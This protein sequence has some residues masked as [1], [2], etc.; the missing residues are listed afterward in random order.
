MSQGRVAE[1]DL[2]AMHQLLHIKLKVGRERNTHAANV[3]GTNGRRGRHTAQTRQCLPAPTISSRNRYSPRFVISLVL[4]WKLTE[5]ELEHIERVFSMFDVSI[6]Q[7]KV[8]GSDGCRTF[9][10]PDGV[11][12]PLRRAESEGPAACVTARA[13]LYGEGSAAGMTPRAHDDATLREQHASPVRAPS[14]PRAPNTP[15]HCALSNYLCLYLFLSRAR[16]PTRPP[17]RPQVPAVGAIDRRAF[18]YAMRRLRFADKTKRRGSWASEQVIREV[19]AGEYPLFAQGEDD[20]SYLAYVDA[21]GRAK[22]EILNGDD[23]GAA[24]ASALSKLSLSFG[25]PSSEAEEAEALRRKRAEFTVASSYGTEGDVWSRSVEAVG[26]RH[27][28][29]CADLFGRALKGGSGVNGPN[30]ITRRDLSPVLQAVRPGLGEADVQALCE[31]A[32]VSGRHGVSFVDVV[33]MVGYC[34]LAS[35]TIGGVSKVT[36]DVNDHAAGRAAAQLAMEEEEAQKKT[37]WST[38]LKDA[39]ETSERAFSDAAAAATAAANAGAAAA[40]IGAAV[41]VR[42][43][44]GGQAHLRSA[45]AQMDEAVASATAAAEAALPSEVSELA[46][47]ASTFASA[48]AG[49]AEGVGGAALSSVWSGLDAA[50]ALASGGPPPQDSDAAARQ[51]LAGLG[52]VRG[53]AGV[54]EGAE[55]ENKRV[56]AKRAKQEA[57]AKAA[58]AAAAEAARKSGAAAMARAAAAAAMDPVFQRQVIG[59]WFKAKAARPGQSNG[60]AWRENLALVFQHADDDGN[61]LVS[62]ADFMALLDDLELDLSDEEAASRFAEVDVDGSGEISFDEFERFFEVVIRDWRA[63]EVG[64]DGRIQH[65]YQALLTLFEP[66]DGIFGNNG[67]GKRKGFLL[68][69]SRNGYQFWS[70]KDPA[71]AKAAGHWSA[72]LGFDDAREAF[73]L[74]AAYQTGIKVSAGASGT[75]VSRLAMLRFVRANAPEGLTLAD[76]DFE[77]LVW[78]PF[79]THPRSAEGADANANEVGRSDGGSAV[80]GLSTEMDLAGFRA[81]AGDAAIS[82]FFQSQLKE[83]RLA[84]S[85]RRKQQVGSKGKQAAK[86]GG[87]GGGLFGMFGAV[88]AGLFGG[89]GDEGEALDE[90]AV[91]EAFD[92][93]DLDGSGDLDI[94]E[95]TLLLTGELGIS[96][97]EDE[98]GALFLKHDTSVTESLDCEQFVGLVKDARRLLGLPKE[99]RDAELLGWGRTLGD[100][101]SDAATAARLKAMA[102]RKKAGQAERAAKAAARAGREMSKKLTKDESA[103]NKGDGRHL[104]RAASRSQYSEGTEAAEAVARMKRE[105]SSKLAAGDYHAITPEDIVDLKTNDGRKLEGTDEGNDHGGYGAPAPGI[106]AAEDDGYETEDSKDEWSDEEGFEAFDAALTI[107]K[108]QSAKISGET[109]KATREAFESASLRVGGASGGQP[110]QRKAAYREIEADLDTDLMAE[111]KAVYDKS[112]SSA[113][114]EGIDA[115]GFVVSMRELKIDVPEWKVRET[116]LEFDAD[117]NGAL[118]FEEFVELCAMQLVA[119]WTAK[120]GSAFRVGDG[121]VGS[122][123]GG[124]A[125]AGAN[126]VK[127]NAKR[128]LSVGEIMGEVMDNKKNE[129]YQRAKAKF[130]VEEILLIEE[131]FVQFA[132]PAS[133][134]G[135]VKV[136]DMKDLALALGLNPRDH[137]LA[138]LAAEVDPLDTRTMTLPDLVKAL[139]RLEGI[140]RKVDGQFADYRA[141]QEVLSDAQVLLAARAFRRCVRATKSELAGVPLMESKLVPAAFRLLG[142][143]IDKEVATL[144]VM[145]LLLGPDEAALVKPTH[146]IARAHHRGRYSS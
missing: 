45:M 69:M 27:L 125:G 23:Q 89:G 94:E 134:R 76:A 111:L 47:G 102:D 9:V 33:V 46:A 62:Q 105:I 5:R 90:E 2:D 66:D 57:E 95:V 87:G 115:D 85:G 86:A 4:Q 54:G 144:W 122:S 58:A 8:R 88:G 93:V 51:A 103:K 120:G 3:R 25:L 17:A 107:S 126:L 104:R 141:D 91:R 124:A 128:A 78:R 73:E 145:E 21:V 36:Q 31:L 121:D 129:E 106:E 113:D 131:A 65:Q 99:E 30:R 19:L 59:N 82:R 136:R 11:S 67:D 96:V 101:S 29:Q 56:A 80:S 135:R 81:F 12:P 70:D 37:K 38:M 18:P 40:T 142:F 123:G 74:A 137:D 20:L 118:D 64:M 119:K 98:I 6:A 24:A 28:A 41:A 26:K 16:P 110:R 7:G 109:A 84:A 75:R 22:D 53:G 44:P 146:I 97:T 108:E 116:F 34:E 39:Q 77:R 32:G 63:R 143:V 133:R 71:E 117:G 10:V 72:R 61:G 127:A 15:R 140:W 138:V 60:E 48:G 49:A 139:A 35:G 79:V 112:L 130:H 114:A 1:N 13:S 68:L 14:S 92:A 43:V 100:E 83:Q 50:S 52:G 42:T 132:E 55:G